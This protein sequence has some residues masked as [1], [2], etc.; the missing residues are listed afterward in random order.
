MLRLHQL[1]FVNLVI[2]FVATLIVSSIVSYFALKEIE[3]E[4]FKNRLITNV[5]I[6]ETELPFVDNFDEFAKKIREKTGD[7]VTIIDKSGKVIAESHF[8]KKEMENHANRPEIIGARKNSYGYSLRYSSTLRSQFLYVAKKSEYKNREIFIRLAISTDKI[9]DDFYRLWIKLTLIFAFSIFVGLI[10]SYLLS[11]NIKREIDKILDYLIEISNK[12]YK[13]KI[14]A[15][16]AK[17]FEEII[18]HLKN[19]AKKLEKREMKK[20]KY[21]EKLKNIS[22]QRSELISAISHEFKNPVAVISGY[23]QTLLEDENMNDKIRKKFLQKIHD[24][25]QKISSM[26]DRLAIAIKFENNDL[27]LQKT[28]FDICEVANE[29]V[30]MLRDKYKERK[31]V[32]NCKSRIVE[33]DKTMIETVLINLIDNALKYSEDEVIVEVDENWVKVI[34]KGIGIK[35]SDIEKITRKF[36]R[37]RRNTWDNSMGLGLYFVTY[38]LKLHNSELLIKSRFGE[39]SEFSF[40]I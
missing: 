27:A 20:K 36:Y 34:D 22:R 28:E 33:A 16:F 1:F 30:K 7:R 38:I 6:I 11:K 10:L 31:I 13:A 25:A 18:Q 15:G 3:I 26:I 32:L 29:A 37:A 8:D 9:L 35:E 12:N 14:S 17:E 2:L 39:G 5:E 40:K 24:N 4:H 23:S 21:T 19:L